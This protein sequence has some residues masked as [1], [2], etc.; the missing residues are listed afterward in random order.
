MQVSW[1]IKAFSALTDAVA[2]FSQVMSDGGDTAAIRQQLAELDSTNDKDRHAKLMAM[3]VKDRAKVL[4]A[5]APNKRL[6]AI[7]S[8]EKDDRT[9]MADVW[10]PAKVSALNAENVEEVTDLELK[11]SCQPA[12][13]LTTVH[14][15]CVW[16]I[17][18]LL[19]IFL[20]PTADAEPRCD[21]FAKP[22]N[23]G[24]TV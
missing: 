6:A 3:T 4:A 18:S 12:L 23:P 2:A 19:E 14:V 9:C 11:M 8:M 15:G 21:T 22:E 16:L 17:C 13:T 7:T 20:C 5:M 10:G 24:D 1:T